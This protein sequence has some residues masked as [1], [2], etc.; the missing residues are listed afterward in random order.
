M[1]IERFLLPF[2]A[3]YEVKSEYTGGAEKPLPH[4]WATTDQLLSGI[5]QLS[6]T[7]ASQKHHEPY[8]P[9]MIPKTKIWGLAHGLFGEGHNKINEY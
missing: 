9:Q 1:L 8:S 2:T 5:S 6:H 3:N 4:T 7:S